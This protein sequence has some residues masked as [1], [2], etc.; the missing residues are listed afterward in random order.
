MAKQVTVWETK[1]G[2]QYPLE[3]AAIAHE[4]ANDLAEELG[5]FM[6]YG[7]FDLTAACRHS[8]ANYDLVRRAS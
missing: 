8:I 7:E 2:Y 4:K 5:K 6:E 1:D 3:A